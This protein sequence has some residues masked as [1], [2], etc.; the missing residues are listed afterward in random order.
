MY[1]LIKEEHQRQLSGIELIASEN[2]TSRAVMECLGSVLTNKYAEGLPGARYYGGNEVVDKVENLCRNR[3]LQA[4]RLDPKKWGVNVQPYSGSSANW[5]LYTAVLQPNDRL[6][7]LDLPHGGHLTHGFYTAKKKVSSSSVYFQSMPYRLGED[8]TVDFDALQK[9]AELFKPK[10]IIC[11]GSAY[12]RE[13]NYRR[14]REIADSVEAKLLMDMAHI[15]GLVA[16]GVVDN[17]FEFAD[18]VTTTTH[19]SLRGPRSG[20][21]FFKKETTEGKSIVEENVNNAVFPSCQGGPHINKI[22]A[23]A[24]QLAEVMTPEFKEYMLQVK[25]NSK[26][27][28]AYLLEK[29]YTLS[30]GGTDNHLLLLNLR[31]QNITG[32]KVE[33]MCDAIHITVNKNSVVGDKS[34]VTPGG[35]RLGTCAMTTRGLKEADFRQVGEFIHHG[36][37]EAIKVQA[38]GGGSKMKLKEFEVVCRQSGVIQQLRKDVSAFAKQFPFPGYADPFDSF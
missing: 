34:A 9:T 23:V 14:F 5:A 30:S 19:K 26:A 32:S 24:A 11:G 28:A 31:P 16:A 38:A 4:Y 25:A 2:F 7:G 18:F 29:G 36:I 17:P 33:K 21:I 1:E 15:S 6:M 10:L 37:Q 22:G 27:L 3:A 13:W 35:V 20:M 12:P 8:G